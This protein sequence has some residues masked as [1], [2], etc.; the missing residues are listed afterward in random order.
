MDCNLLGAAVHRISQARLLEW[1]A[2]ILQLKKKMYD[3]E[4]KC[5]QCCGRGLRGR[6][7]G[8]CRRYRK[9]VAQGRKIKTSKMLPALQ[10]SGN[11]EFH[12]GVAENLHS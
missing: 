3:R 12:E 4:K 8:P 2:T 11:L 10:P 1:V 9:T 5:S 6:E 7:E